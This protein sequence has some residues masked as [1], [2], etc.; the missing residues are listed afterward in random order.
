MPPIRITDGTHFFVLGNGGVLFSEPQQEICS[1][2]SVATFVWCCLEEGL[3]S[4]AITRQFAN[5]FSVTLAEANPAICEILHRWQGLGYITG[6]DL[7]GA[8]EIDITTA[9]GRLLVNPELREAFAAA[10]EDTA[11]HLRIRQA[12]LNTFLDLDP[13]E[14]EYQAEALWHKKTSC[15]NAVPDSDNAVTASFLARRMTR[16]TSSFSVRYYRLAESSFCVR[17]HTA[18]Q[19]LAVHPVFAHLEIPAPGEPDF[20]LA[21]VAQEQ[22][23]FLLRDATPLAFASEI[24]ELAPLLTTVLATIAVKSNDLFLKIHAGVVG[25]NG[26]CILLPAAAGS[27]KTTLTAALIS[28]GFRYFSDEVA[29]VDRQNA[30]VHSMPVS[31]SI[32]PSGS[33][34]LLD[35]YPDIDKLPKHLRDDGGYIRYLCPSSENTAVNWEDTHPVSC[36]VFPEYDI[37]ASTNIQRLDLS[38][39]F[40]Q[41]IKESTFLVPRIEANH[42]SLCVRI[43][44]TALCFSLSFSSLPAAIEVIRDLVDGKS[45]SSTSGRP[46]DEH[47]G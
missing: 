29:F 34:P 16:E 43:L 19:A 14:L 17:Y 46:G 23:H 37:D 9:L 18:E 35:Y 47:A 26:Q 30:L 33:K 13:Q 32:K 21:I 22:G 2:N 20:V 12:D 27:G 4:D 1:F 7:S 38:E 39:A 11:A 15:Y 25:R 44:R 10:P 6:I 40:G 8:T 5:T 45:L 31:L 42:I 3:S 36:I 41:L 24:S 28:S